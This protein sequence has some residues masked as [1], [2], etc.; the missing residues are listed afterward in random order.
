MEIP[1]KENYLSRKIYL[2]TGI[3]KDGDGRVAEALAEI[4]ANRSRNDDDS[5]DSGNGIRR[6]AHVSREC[7]YSNFLKCQPLNFKGT[8]GVVGLTQWFEKMESVFHI[9]N[10]TELSL[11]CSRMFPEESNKIEKYVDGLPDKI[12]GSMMA[13]KAKTMQDAI[14]F[15]TEL[16]VQ[17]IHTL[18]ERQAKNNR[19]LDN[20]NQA[21]QQPLKKQSVAIAYTAGPR[22]RKEYAGTLP[23][24]SKCKFHHNGQ[25]TNQ[26]HENQSG[27]TEARGLVHALGGGE[28]NQD[29]NNMEDD[30]NA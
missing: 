9:S 18:A 4:E 29:L 16:M 20:N 6:Q 19:K 15:A 10:C 22:E 5:H 1:V 23:L 21:Q 30:I 8:E 3:H 25:C 7:T 17:K 13:S 27:G 24:C 28:T 2:I 11:M 26:N 12:Y 14:E